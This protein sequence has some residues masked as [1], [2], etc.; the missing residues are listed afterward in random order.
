MNN[1]GVLNSVAAAAA[2]NLNQ[3]ASNAKNLP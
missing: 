2:V 3:T 1:N